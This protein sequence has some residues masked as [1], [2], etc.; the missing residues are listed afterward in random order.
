[1]PWAG[2]E[3]RDGRPYSKPSVQ[4]SV[5]LGKEAGGGGLLDNPLSGST[6]VILRPDYGSM[7]RREGEVAGS[8][9]WW[10]WE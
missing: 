5:A 10:A 2:A 8:G 6:E 9:G 4:R 3:K 1:M 7:M